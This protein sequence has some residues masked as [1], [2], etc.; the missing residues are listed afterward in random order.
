[1]RVVADLL[2]AHSDVV[3]ERSGAASESEYEHWSSAS[4]EL[5]GPYASH[6]AIDGG[7]SFVVGR[8]AQG[9]DRGANACAQLPRIDRELETGA[10]AHP[11]AHAS[12]RQSAVRT[13][14]APT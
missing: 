14:N 2:L 13:G 4:A 5:F 7:E 8:D 6:P 3:E 1:M 10:R 12:T 11:E 9:I